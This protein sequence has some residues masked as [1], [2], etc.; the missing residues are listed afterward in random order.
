MISKAQF[1]LLLDVA[2]AATHRGLAADGRAILEGLLAWNPGYRPA[3]IGLA[4][5]HAAV[6][7][8]ARAEAIL[9]NDVLAQDPDD[10][11]AQAMLGLTLRLAGRADE[12]IAILAELRD[13]AEGEAAE[14]AGALAS[15]S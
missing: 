2:L 11:Q 4:F 1:S 6:D 3:L 12:A 8:F 13:K 5:N 7:D 15:E 9:R 14:L 10:A